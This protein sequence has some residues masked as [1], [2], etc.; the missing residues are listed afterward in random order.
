MV[1]GARKWPRVE[2]GHRAQ[3]AGTMARAASGGSSRRGV[4]AVGAV[5]CAVAGRRPR[6]A[7]LHRVGT[8][9]RAAGPHVQGDP[10]RPELSLRWDGSF[11][12]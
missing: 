11:G 3:G 4:A 8:R 7:R 2:R 9:A 10:I 12:L 5:D 1:S 6:A